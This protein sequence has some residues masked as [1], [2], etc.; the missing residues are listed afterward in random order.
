M[1]GMRGEYHFDDIV[2]RKAEKAVYMDGYV[3]NK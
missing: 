3:K 1:K 2:R